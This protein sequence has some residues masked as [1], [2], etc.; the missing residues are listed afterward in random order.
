V[1][2]T[3]DAVAF[4]A[5]Q[6]LPV[7]SVAAIFRTSPVGLVSLASGANIKTPKE[8]A[9]KTMGFVPGEVPALLLPALLNATGVDQNA[10]KIATTDQ[11][12][13]TATLLLGRVDAIGS[14]TTGSYPI[15]NDQTNGGAVFLRY[16]DYG[17]ETIANS[18]AA[19]D[20]LLREQPDL[21]RRFV[22]ASVR[23]WQDAQKNPE[24]VIEVLSRRYANVAPKPD[25]A[26]A[27]LKES[28]KLMDSK[29]SAGKPIGFQTDADWN[30][31]LDV[32]A[33]YAD[34]EEKRPLADYFTNDYLP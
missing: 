30:A 11:P 27:Q 12:T 18:I 28:F 16:A 24:E 21:V 9:G 22:R 3:G 19:S 17:V 2:S 6:K 23:A 33:R 29:N 20:K 15:I 31:M 4:A 34:L 1:V 7:K 5:A 10:V 32:L 25:V 26:L 13:A 14:F 8:L